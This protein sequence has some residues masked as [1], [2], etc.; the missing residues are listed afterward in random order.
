MR[1]LEIRGNNISEFQS[2]DSF[3]RR[4]QALTQNSGGERTHLYGFLSFMDILLT[5]TLVSSSL[6]N[7]KINAVS[8]RWIR[9]DL[10]NV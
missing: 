6:P 7:K 3:T 9:V 8:R 4:A 10:S 5:G 1:N 2:S